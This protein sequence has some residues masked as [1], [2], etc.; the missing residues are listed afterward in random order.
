M[1]KPAL[2][3]AV[4]LGLTLALAAQPPTKIAQLSMGLRA[5]PHADVQLDVECRALRG[6][7]GQPL[8]V[9][10]A[11][12]DTPLPPPHE[13]DGAGEWLRR[14]ATSLGFAGLTP[15][16]KATS[17]WL[18]SEVWTYE[19]TRADL[20]LFDA[21]VSLYWEGDTCIGLLNRTPKITTL[22]A[23]TAAPTERGVLY[24][25]RDDSGTVVLA[26]QRTSTTEMHTV[27][28]VVH[29]GTVLHRILEQ[30]EWSAAPQAATITEYTFAGMNFPDQIWADSKGLIWFSEPQ[31]GRVSVFDPTTST[32]RQFAT[33]GYGGNDGLQVDDKDRVW[34]GLYNSN[35]GLGVIDAATGAFT[36]YP[37]PYSGA[38]MAIPTQTT[39]G[40][41]L[42]TDHLA[43]KVSEFDPRTGTWL[44]TITMPT[45]S[46]PVGGT[47]E[48]ETGNVYFPLYYFNGLGRWSP[49]AT[50][51]TRIAAPSASGPAFCGVHDGKVYFSYWLTNKLGVYDT[52][53]GTFTEHLWRAGETGG[54][55]AMAPNGHAVI[56]TRNRGYI[57]VFDPIAQTFT[58][59]V[60]PSVNS[61]LKDGLTVAPDGVIW[62]TLTFTHNKIAKL[63]L[64]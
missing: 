60:I 12:P 21:E 23:D 39:S 1:H 63:V 52:K 62:F 28:E 47:L 37:P 18:G 57:A 4:S 40:T 61:G 34:F 22:P 14:H 44:G 42:V 55:L 13:R 3:G 16:F 15:R 31:V 45:S 35:N 19:L 20:V 43:E 26:E 11:R 51:I 46:Y 8:V 50:T 59:Y 53:T 17:D 7:F 58:D 2:V 10:A 56:G 27:T 29:D 36:R 38:Q 48:R 5:A 32:F 6:G 41:I 64:P 9:W 25:L 49:G 24:A 33:P 30:R 54:P